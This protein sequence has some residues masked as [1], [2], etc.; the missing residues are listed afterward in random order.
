MIPKVIHYCWFGQGKKPRLARK[1]IDS[2]NKHCN[3]F[4]IIE[5]NESNFN[6]DFNEYTRF[7][8]DNK[9]WAFLSDYARL[10]VIKENGGIYFDT[11]VEVIKSFDELLDA[12]AFFG[13]ENDSNIATGLGFG[14]IPDHFSINL[15]LEQ[16]DIIKKG[17]DGSFPLI[18]CPRL[19]T[20]ALL[21]LGLKLEDKRQ[22]I[23]NIDI[24]P[25]DYFNP[26]DDPT[27][28]LRITDNTYSIHWYGKSW[29]SNRKKIRSMIARPFHRLLG[30][31][32]FRKKENDRH[33]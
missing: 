24:Y 14:A 13:F 22:T 9:R 32:F 10:M 5:W 20:E 11:D 26:F 4:E 3:G 18:P 27:G 19:N 17:S 12:E 31:D 30:V 2:W 16:Y 1:C 23:G 25:S 7:C 15:M 29:I 6:V 33:E 21:Q 8:Y 28:R